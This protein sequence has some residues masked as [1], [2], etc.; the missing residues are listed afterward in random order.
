MRVKVEVKDEYFVEDMRALNALRQKIARVLKDE[1][2]IT[3]KVDL[4]EHNSL[5]KSEG[6]AQRVVDRRS[7]KQ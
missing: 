4:V 2:L 5:P 3:P 7:S 6:K 1:L